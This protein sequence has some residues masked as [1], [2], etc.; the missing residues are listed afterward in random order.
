MKL[1]LVDPHQMVRQGLRSLLEKGGFTVCG[2]AA[3]GIQAVDMAGRLRPGVVLMDLAPPVV[4][5]AKATR[6]IRA[7]FAKVQVIALSGDAN[8]EQVL[9]MID[10]GAAG[11]VLKEDSFEHLV[12]AINAVVAGET[13]YT[14]RL[15]PIVEAHFQVEFDERSDGTVTLGYREQEVLQLLADGVTT[16]QA[17]AEL[18]LSAKTVETY[19]TRIVK[20]LGVSGMA[21]LTRYAVREGMTSL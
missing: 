1:L 12:E 4:N 2:E 17:A 10:A 19:R 18:G 9:Q 7:A 6:Q 11:Y 5:G 20:K 16:R 3:D 8:G 15:V 14:A 21:E 13:Y